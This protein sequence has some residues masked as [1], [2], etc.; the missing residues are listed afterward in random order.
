MEAI[1]KKY[2]ISKYG[3]LPEKPLNEL[4]QSLSIYNRLICLQKQG[5]R[6]DFYKELSN[7]KC[8]DE[9]YYKKIVENETVATVKYIYS[10]FSI[11][12][13]YYIWAK[14]A[15]N[16][17]NTIPISLGGPWYSSA[18]LLGLPCVLTHASVDLYNWEIVDKTNEFSLDN[19]K[20]IN[21]MTNTDD[22]AWFYKVMIAIEG[23]CGKILPKL[24]LTEF[25]EDNIKELLTDISSSI[26]EATKNI[27]RM[28]EGCEPDFFFNKLRIFLGGSNDP[29]LFPDGLKLD[30]MSVGNVKFVGGSAAQS[31]LIQALDIFFDV[32]HV[33]HAKQFL[34]S[35]RDYMPQKHKNYLDALTENRKKIRSYVLDSNQ[36]IIK[37]YNDGLE[38]LVQFRS[39]H[40]GIVH[41]YILKFLPKKE[42]TIVNNIHGNK[43]S[44][45][46][47]PKIF[48]TDV[49]TATKN[50]VHV[51]KETNYVTEC[52]FLFTMWYIWR[53][54]IY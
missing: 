48:L 49:I 2:D 8:E 21:T 20:I 44:G 51:I 23:V 53:N 50:T 19:I 26:S 45:G 24:L 46:T 4:P 5:K 36:E 22:E 14:G 27:Q 11:I 13:H 25:D 37:L 47:D 31:T 41:D 42:N 15:D 3:F 6:D 16:R 40:L 33:E 38:K 30:G 17:E 12:S 32:E 7:I 39:S 29:K 35:M 10:V 28:R 1:C 34:D 18:I 43:G 9:K 52:I 54:F